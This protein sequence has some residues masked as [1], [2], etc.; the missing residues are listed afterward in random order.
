MFQ[1][2]RGCRRN[3]GAG[4]RFVFADD[5]PVDGPGDRV[6][7]TVDGL[8]RSVGVPFAVTCDIDRNVEVERPP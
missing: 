4:R 7:D 3:P 2:K 5:I 6:L 8:Y 1:V